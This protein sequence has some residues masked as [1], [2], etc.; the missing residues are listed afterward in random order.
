MKHQN[1][2]K[3]PSLAL[4]YHLYT[5]P[6][7]KNSPA[8]KGTLDILVAGFEAYG[9]EFLDLTLQIAQMPG[10]RLNV[11]VVF[12]SEEEKSQYLSERPELADFFN[13]DGS[14]KDD[15]GSYGDINFVEHSFLASKE[16][17]LDFVCSLFDKTSYDHAF[18]AVGTDGENLAV[19]EM[20]G[21]L[22]RTSFAT[23]EETVSV[24]NKKNICPVYMSENVSSSPVFADVERMAFNV[25]LIWNQNLNINF[26]KV[27]KEF[28][29][30]YNH[31]SCVLYVFSMKYKLHS[32]GIDIEACTPAEAARSFSSFISSDRARMD[33]LVCLEHRR[34]VTEKL[35]MGYTRITDLNECAEGKMKDEK[36]K[37]HVC[38][39]RSTPARGLAGGEWMSGGKINKAKWDKPSKGDLNKLD[40]LDRVS[41]ELHLMHMKNARKEKKNDLFNGNTV[42]GIIN[43]IENDTVCL[44]AFQEL[45][46]CM[47]D[48][49][50]S[51]SEQWKR[52]EGLRIRFEEAVAQAEKI[53]V[54]VKETIHNLY[55]L[56]HARFYPIL[57]SQQ[58][59]DYKYNDVSLVNSVPFILTY[60]D[61]LYMV[62]PYDTGNNTKLFNNTAAPTV[63]NP[64][65][66]LYIA[67]CTSE[68]ELLQI[69][70]SLQN[71]SEYMKKAEF[72]ANVEFIIGLGAGANAGDAKETEREFRELSD[73]RVLRVKL[74]PVREIM[75]YITFL[76]G[77]LHTRSKNKMNFLVEKNDTNLSG[78]MLGSGLYKEFSSYSYDSAKMRFD[79]IHDCDIVKYIHAKTFITV[80]D[81]FGFKLSTSSTSNKPEF[82][83]DYKELWAKYR[84]ST[85]EWK[86]LCGLLRRYS[87]TNDVI[88]RFRREGARAVN[89]S[90]YSFIIPLKCKKTVENILAALKKVDIIGEQSRINTSTTQSCILIIN[91]NY[92]NKRQFDTLFSEMNKLCSKELIHC[93][94]DTL[95]NVVMVVYN[96]LTVKGLD[97]E[98]LSSK[99]YELMDFFREKRYLINL[100]Y[101]RAAKKASFTYATPQIKDLLSLEGR[102]LEIYTYHKAQE[103]GAFDDIRSSFEIDWENSIAKNEFDCVLTKGFSSLFIECKATRE[104]KSEF[105][106][107]IY[108]LADYFGINAKIV[109]VADTQDNDNTAASN[110]KLRE[111]GK[112]L[113]VITVSDRTDIGN[114]GN[115]LLQIIKS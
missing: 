27:R 71:I 62:I 76:K 53:S 52:Y 113:E 19:A 98:K 75:E 11:T 35:C 15:P 41:V 70:K 55:E 17:D 85:N 16:S 23:E 48:I 54:N 58:Y 28:K 20:I 38:I 72:R 103:T 94:I 82:Y 61:S 63:I 78:V 46:T 22:C 9:R 44:S 31:D 68:E 112:K 111:R 83:D 36:K 21:Q 108:T 29:K 6:L 88:A 13:I 45:I 90:E 74:V 7:Y 32:I 34:W 14:L 81:M 3:T 1:G 49:W 109:I 4:K 80:V 37:R 87:M 51:D 30:P 79:V 67:Y 47:K 26:G 92:N 99:G 57:A 12:S 101:D 110:E 95:H 106:T 77:Y 25:H 59:F 39:V 33:E 65:N 102:M 56:L 97:C 8:D 69:K 107:K 40:D 105:Y 100:S 64:S 66:L 42:T 60:S 50:N 43:Q 24:K 104:I 84:G 86:Y 89:G 5:E 114:I 96:D 91:D 18:A 10:K 2:D 73:R 115:T 93:E